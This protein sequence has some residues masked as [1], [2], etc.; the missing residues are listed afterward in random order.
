MC[1]Q[2]CLGDFFED[3]VYTYYN[4]RVIKIYII[5]SKSCDWVLW[6]E[7]EDETFFCVGSVFYALG[8]LYF[9]QM[10]LLC[11]LICFMS[12]KWE[13]TKEWKVCLSVT[14]SP[15]LDNVV[16]RGGQ[17]PWEAIGARDY[18]NYGDL[19]RFHFML[20]AHNLSE[21]KRWTLSLLDFKTRCCI[22]LH[23]SI[24]LQNA[25]LIQ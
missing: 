19:G 18:D 8:V 17:I 7:K 14:V 24:I 12:A 9:Y 6:P 13:V 23:L 21:I 25:P 11:W 3:D 10:L 4:T 5:T 16:M 20:S 22:I 1:I 2:W 15:L